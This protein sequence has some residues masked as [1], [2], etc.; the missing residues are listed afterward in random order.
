MANFF[1][2]ETSDLEEGFDKIALYAL[3]DT[4]RH[5][6]KQIDGARWQSKLGPDE[7]I[8]HTLPGLEGPKYGKVVAFFKRK[9]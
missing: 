4:V 2:C 8:S 3:E 9:Q 7:D 6:A 5:A 1:Q